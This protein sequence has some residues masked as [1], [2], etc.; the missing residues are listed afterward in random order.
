MSKEQNSI[1]T[2]LGKISIDNEAIAG[3]A[4]GA[5]VE[6]M[7]VVGMAAVSVKDGWGKLLKRESLTQGIIVNRKGNHVSLDLHVI[8]A[9]GSNILAIAS[10]LTETVTY[11]IEE[12]TGMTVDNIR[13]FVDGVR[14]I[15]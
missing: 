14:V 7:G 5:A 15:D 3:Y 12:H 9:Y 8:V 6:C 11:T 10:N 2:S 4:G 13:I 1:D